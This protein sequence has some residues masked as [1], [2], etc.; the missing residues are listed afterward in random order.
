MKSAMFR[1]TLVSLLFGLS[2]ATTAAAQDFQKSYKVGAGSKV[3][4]ANVSGDVIVSGYDGDSII[5][6]AFKKGDDRDQV[7]VEDRSTANR[8]DLAARYPK[9]CRCDA[10]IRFEVQVPRSVSYEFEAISSVSGDVNVGDVSGQLTAS[11]VSGNVQVK[12]VRGLV[13]AS[14]VSG[15][16]D[17][18]ITR[19]E[20]AKDMKF[21]SVSGDVSV[22]LPSSLD[23]EISMSSFSGSIETDFPIEV[24]EGKHGTGNSARGRVGGGSRS[25]GMTSVSGD[26]S[27]KHN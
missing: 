25:L 7:E 15:D 13:N 23:A 6:R 3:Q 2:L 17:V 22:R 24:R 4:I 11:S 1:L 5:V 27:L 14:S 16:V 8:V 19:L 12:S 20:G 26:L 10:S 9:N 21:T 18:D